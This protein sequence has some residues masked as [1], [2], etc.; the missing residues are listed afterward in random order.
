MPS[1]WALQRCARQLPYACFQWETWALCLKKILGVGKDIFG[2]VCLGSL[3]WFGFWVFRFGL[4]DVDK[5]LNIGIN[6]FSSMSLLPSGSS[7]KEVSM[8]WMCPSWDI[9]LAEGLLSKNSGHS[10]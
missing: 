6:L 8:R 9:L 10:A 7:A 4:V 2:A 5:R 3:F 1:A